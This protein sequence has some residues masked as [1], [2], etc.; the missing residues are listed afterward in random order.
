MLK[1]SEDQQSVGAVI[2]EFKSIEN[3]LERLLRDLTA[4]RNSWDDILKLQY[5]ACEAFANLYKPLDPPPEPDAPYVPRET[6]REFMQKCLGLQKMYSDERADLLQE[7]ALIT[8]KVIRPVEEAKAACKGLQKTLKHRENMKLDYER[9]LS[10]AEHARKK[11][12]RSLKEEQTLAKCEGDLTQAK[13]DY[14][15]ADEQVVTTFPPVSQAVAGLMP[16]IL[17]AQVM[18]QTTLVGQLY[19]SLD[20]YCRAQN[21]PS[22]AP[23]DGEIIGR[24]ESEFT[25]FRKE[26]EG[27]LTLIS[28]GRAVN[29]SMT[30]PEKEGSSYTGLGIRNKA[31]SGAD[32]GRGYL[33]KSKSGQSIPHKASFNSANSAAAPDEEEAPPPRP[34]RPGGSAA[35]SPI[36]SPFPPVNIGNKP[37]M[38]SSSSVNAYAA[39]YDQKSSAY[40]HNGQ[41]AP[42]DQKTTA[43]FPTPQPPP[44]YSESPTYGNAHS[45]S[46]ASSIY[47]TPRNGLSPAPSTTQQ[48]GDYFARPGGSSLASSAAA[49]A[50]KKPPPVPVKRL[51]SAQSQVVTA[52]YDFDGQNAGDLSF[53]EGDRITVIRKTE[54]VDDWWE[55]SLQGRKGSFPANYVQL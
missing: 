47:H 40:N 29:Q 42:Y 9:Y 19:T 27:G 38:P 2:A 13:I 39:A 33:H 15:T 24:W 35:A 11:D 4:W 17:A 10:R 3:M 36:A 44:P 12:V 46:V 14:Q 30:I 21:M 6:P 7:V 18:L 34:P 54:S 8:S 48:S 20:G 49:A 55:G 41:A 26:L 25:A 51:P 31:R 5:D 53:R 23:S 45:P 22:P 37:R 1:R 52:L 28:S 16:Y 32:A 50:K 43:Q